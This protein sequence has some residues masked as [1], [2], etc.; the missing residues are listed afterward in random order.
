MKIVIG[1]LIAGVLSVGIYLGYVYVSAGT[2]Q[3]IRQN[4]STPGSFD[5]PFVEKPKTS[6]SRT[7]AS[8]QPAI[9]PFAQPTQVYQ[10]PFS[11]TSSG[12][13]EYQNPFEVLR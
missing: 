11:S 6:F 1:V 4:V 8:A 13:Q 9:N 2:N 5:N 12:S 10:N 7:N 3:P